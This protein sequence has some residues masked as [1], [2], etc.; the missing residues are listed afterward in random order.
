[1]VRTGQQRERA[2]DT[3]EPPHSA[4]ENLYALLEPGRM[5]V[6]HKAPLFERPGTRNEMN[7]SH[8]N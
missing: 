2:H 3:V 8:V 7:P 1:M 5:Q 4:L 6:P